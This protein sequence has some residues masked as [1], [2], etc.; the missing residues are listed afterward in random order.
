M[1]GILSRLPHLGIL[2]VCPGLLEHIKHNIVLSAALLEV[3][4]RTYLHGFN[5]AGR[6]IGSGI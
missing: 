1:V 3:Q 4:Q 5:N 6:G 2:A